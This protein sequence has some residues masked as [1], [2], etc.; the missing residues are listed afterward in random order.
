VGWAGNRVNQEVFWLGEK[1]FVPAAHF[2]IEEFLH[3]T[4]IA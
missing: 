1:S 3:H 2:G 4:A